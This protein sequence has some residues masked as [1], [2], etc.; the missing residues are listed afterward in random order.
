[1]MFIAGFVTGLVVVLYCTGMRSLVFKDVP[2]RDL[3]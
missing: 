2:E 1:M 3:D